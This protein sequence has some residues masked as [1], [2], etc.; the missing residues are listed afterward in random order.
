MIS[1]EFY[2]DKGRTGQHFLGGKRKHFEHKERTVTIGYY[3][4]TM[5][6]GDT[7]FSLA[8]KIFGASRYWTILTDMN[9]LKGVDEWTTGDEIHLP[10]RVVFD[11]EINNRYFL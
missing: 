10:D 4:Y 3:V 2:T 7:L 1:R 8:E 11:A 6:Y 5:T 9:R